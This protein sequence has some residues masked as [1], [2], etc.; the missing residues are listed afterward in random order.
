M[1]N[2]AELRSMERL[3]SKDDLS[4][5]NVASLTVLGLAAAHEIRTHRAQALMPAEIDALGFACE[6]LAGELG[7]AI[8]D[9]H[10]Q[11]CEAALAT[12]ERLLTIQ[13]ASR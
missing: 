8:T 9:K 10:R 3:C 5:G 13:K 6:L 7:H 1:M 2:D 12:I 11:N 4:D